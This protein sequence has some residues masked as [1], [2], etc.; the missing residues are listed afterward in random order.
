MSVAV[1]GGPGIREEL[2]FV[3]PP[4]GLVDLHRFALSALDDTGYLFALRSTDAPDVRLFVI[5]P[6]AYF[7]GYTPRLDPEVLTA[8]E[9]DGTPAVLLV[10]VHPGQDGQPPYANLLAPVV[11]NPRT[12]R[13]A[14]V[15]LD[16]AE[17]PLRAPLTATGQAA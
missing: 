12:G 13:A 5:P 6:R 1:A 14:Q 11:V 8:L 16:G 3:A 4:P 7:P 9:L 17:Y 15:V 2:D 10:V